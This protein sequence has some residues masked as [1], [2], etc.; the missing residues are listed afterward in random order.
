MKIAIDIDGTITECPEFFVFLTKLFRPEHEIHIITGRK[1]TERIET[2][3]QL[4]ALGIEY[5]HLHIVGPKKSYLT[6]ETMWT[7][8]G[9]FCR[10]HNIDV[11][12]EDMD[13][14]IEHIPKSTLVFKIRNGWNFCFNQLAWL[15]KHDAKV[16]RL[17]NGGARQG[18]QTRPDGS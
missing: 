13:E 5:H 14:F 9:D 16:T 8:K 3:E 15:R 1:Q 4:T 18:D 17:N 12:F 2:E 6:E 7:R 10:E 11:L